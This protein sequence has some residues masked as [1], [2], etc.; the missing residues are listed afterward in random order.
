MYKGMIVSDFDGT[1]YDKHN[2]FTDRDL[3]TLNT[4]QLKNYVRVLA[5]GR[6]LKSLY[7]A[8]DSSFPV[9]YVVFSSGAGVYHLE[10]E[11]LLR[12][13]VFSAEQTEKLSRH[14]IV[15]GIDF[16]V[17]HPIPDNHYFHYYSAR[18]VLEAEGG[19]THREDSEGASSDYYARIEL[20]KSYAMPFDWRQVRR[21]EATQFVLITPNDNNLLNM[22]QNE[23]KDQCSVIWSSSPLD[24]TSLWIE[25]F[26]TGAH[27]G[28]GIAWLAENLQV[29]QEASMAVGN[30]YNDLHMLEWSDRGFV[31]ANAPEGLLKRFEV[32]PECGRSGFSDA[33][34]RWLAARGDSL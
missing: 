33:V 6:S 22:I 10:K 20:Y 19:K 29:D 28:S 25:L 30:D 12:R 21:L 5:T 32:V 17:H 27:K 26:P 2:G 23:F 8:V 7:R 13:V 3:A 34:Q 11:E 31:V 24:G 14:L 16:M 9:D 1:L 15:L 18:E 4:L